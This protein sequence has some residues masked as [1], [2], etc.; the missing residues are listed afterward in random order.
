MIRLTGTLTCH[1]PQQAATVRRLLPDHIA[2]SRAEPG[3]LTF[4]VVPTDNPFVWRLDETFTNKQAFEA[5]QTRTRTSA[6][7]TATTDL[8]RDFNMTDVAD[9]S[10]ADDQ[11]T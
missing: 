7:F 1:T 2:L 9:M 3:C 8:S 10:A 6:W 11:R 5:H 4:D